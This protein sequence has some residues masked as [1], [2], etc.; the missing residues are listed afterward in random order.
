MENAN[1]E[2]KFIKASELTHASNIRQVSTPKEDAEM[3]ASILAQDGVVQNLIAAPRKSDGTIAVFAGGRRLSNSQALIADGAL[4]AD[5]E[6]PVM[7]MHDIDP[8][9]PEAIEMALSENV[10]RASMD[11]IDECNA[12]MM[13]A[14][15]GRSD[16]DIASAFDYRPRTVRER[17]L[18]ANLAPEA[19][20]LVRSEER[21]LEWARAL[22]IADKA[23]QIKICG[24]IATNANAWR[25]ADDVRN[26]LTKSTIDVSTAL[27]DV[28]EYKGVIVSDFFEGDKFAD[29]EKFWELQNEAV[30]GRVADLEAEGFGRGVEVTYEPLEE[31]RF[32]KTD[33][34][35]EAMAIIEV[36]PDGKVREIKGV[37]LVAEVTTTVDLNEADKAEEKRILDSDLAGFEVRPTARICEY[38]AAQRTA[39]LQSRMAGSFR[40]SLEY[41]ILAF[42]GHRS[43]TFS[44]NTFQLAGKDAS[45]VGEAFNSRMDVV[46]EINE[47]T[48]GA[49]DQPDL[50]AR[51]ATQVTIIR[52]MDDESLQK[53]FAMVVSL[54]VGQQKRNSADSSENV[55]SNIFGAQIDVR[56]YWT[57]DQAFF[58]MMSSE[59]LRR[60]AGELLPNQNALAFASANRKNLVKALSSAFQDARDGALAKS[61]A[62]K[63]NMWV[64]GVMSFPAH[65]VTAQEIAI[66]DTATA[67]FDLESAIFADSDAA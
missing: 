39:M 38:A 14:T 27:F 60:L 56:Q 7:I 4:D 18:I 1:R 53:L 23:M 15:S 26:Y 59:D 61:L 66:D 40:A 2:L 64:P 51:E 41:T 24:D 37:R 49:A 31:W 55:L 35:D 21:N 5:F 62:D 28:E 44:A 54:R 8:D 20:A 29:I 3:R 63:L 33:D 48:S 67:D 58:D 19:Q 17:L 30:A 45:H 46:N 12:M 22:T 11:Y 32:E 6:L 43:A 52:Q 13:L 65:I 50:D 25:S 34:K 36:S 16:E 47:M 57:P 10:V 42:L 9:S